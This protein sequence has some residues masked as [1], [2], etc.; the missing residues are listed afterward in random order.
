MTKQCDQCSKELTSKW[1]KEKTR[2]CSKV[3]SN[4]YRAANSD[5]YKV[6]SLKLKERSKNK[7]WGFQCISAEKKAENNR[8]RT[9]KKLSW[10]EKVFARDWSELSWEYKRMRIMIEQEGKC[11]FCNLSEWRGVKI[12]LEVDHIDGCRT[13]NLRENLRALCPNCHMTTDTYR[14]RNKLRG[15]LPPDNVVYEK[16]KEVG[17]VRQTLLAFNVAAKGAN[18]ARVKTIIQKFEPYSQFETIIQYN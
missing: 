6:H 3:C 16:Y 12:S 4:L 14:G 11:A 2:F 13:N 18:Y 15:K 8:S 1:V 5:F 17:N 10:A 7:P 9:Y